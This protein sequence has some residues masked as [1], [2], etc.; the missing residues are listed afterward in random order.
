[1]FN[2]TKIKF[3]ALFFL[4]IT[5]NAL[6]QTKEPKAFI[7][8][9]VYDFGTV[10]SGEV[11]KHSFLIINKGKANLNIN[12]VSSSCGCTVA[13][14]TKKVLL[15]ND[16]SIIKVEFNSKNR[17]GFQKK[18]IS[19][20][21]DDPNNSSIQFTI[22]GNVSKETSSLNSNEE[23][24]NLKFKEDTYD[25]GIINEGEKV[26]H[27]FQFTNTGKTDLEILDVRTSC[28]CTAAI[29][30]KKILKP[31]EEGSLKV[32]FDSSNRSGKVSRT[33]SLL[34]NDPVEPTKTLTIFADI[35]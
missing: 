3:V 29:L 14:P 17:S 33:V 25:F 9:L 5:F 23:K 2:K 28:G 26:E 32:Q 27:L 21:T 6:G 1:M 15:P 7:P 10:K 12:K 24:T 30:S 18:I 31:G 20:S 13:E 34:S 11:V 19:V 4:I 35:K 22:Q 16:T 8:E